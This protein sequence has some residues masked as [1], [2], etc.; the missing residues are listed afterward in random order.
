M[1]KRKHLTLYVESKEDCGG[2]SY[3]LVKTYKEEI[4]A[5][6]FLEDEDC[7]GFYY[8]ITYN[9][10]VYSPC[11]FEEKFET[12]LEAIRFICEQEGLTKKYKNLKVR[13]RGYWNSEVGAITYRD[14]IETLNLAA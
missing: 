1:A 8:Y 6:Y 11:F 2:T 10:D 4:A 13:L 12:E 7:T 5:I 9:I 14:N 3:T